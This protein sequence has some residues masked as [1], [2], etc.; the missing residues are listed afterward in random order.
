MA[1]VIRLDRV[2]SVYAGHVYSV[3]ASVDVNN[4]SIGVVGTLVSNQRETRT[5]VQPVTGTIA[6]DKVVLVASPEVVYDQAT[7][8]SADITNFT[9]LANKPMRAY[10]INKD[11]EFSV[12]KDAIT[13]I[14]SD[15]VVGNFVVAQNASYKMKEV[16]STSTENF[17]GRIEAIETYATPAYVG[18]GGTLTPGISFVRIRVIK[19]A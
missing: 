10:E 1:S 14:G 8:A 15:P 9:N 11:D 17:V 5:L 4:G 18:A 3:Q 7:W 16:A 12:T 6:S 2:K 19:N 13:L